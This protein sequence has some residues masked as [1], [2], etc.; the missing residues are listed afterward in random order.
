[1]IEC[2]EDQEEGAHPEARGIPVATACQSPNGTTGPT[3]LT[4][5]ML[6]TKVEITAIR[7]PRDRRAVDTAPQDRNQAVEADGEIEWIK[8]VRQG[9]NQTLTNPVQMMGSKNGLNPQRTEIR[10]MIRTESVGS[11]ARHHLDEPTGFDI[12]H[13]PVP[14][15]SMLK[16]TPSA[17]VIAGAGSGSGSLPVFG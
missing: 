6:S 2:Q 7:A 13:A 8:K 16:I 10:G 12:H 1:M 14:Q 5:T 17:C 4:Q 3:N 15:P 11:K 9:F